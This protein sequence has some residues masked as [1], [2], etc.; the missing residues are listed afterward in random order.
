[1]DSRSGSEEAARLG[2]FSPLLV[3]LEE[4]HCRIDE[5]SVA[6]SNDGLGSHVFSEFGGVSLE[7]FTLC[8]SASLG[9]TGTDD[10]RV[11][12]AS[13]AVLLLDVDLRK[14]EVLRVLVCKVVFHVSPG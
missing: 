11:D 6:W 2:S 4:L 13:D 8:A 5:G 3:L 14:V 7:S 1:M 10:A 12:A 9:G